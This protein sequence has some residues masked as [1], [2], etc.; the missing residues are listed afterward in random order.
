[1][2][3]DSIEVLNTGNATVTPSIVTDLNEDT[4]SQWITIENVDFGDLS[5]VRSD[6]AGNSNGH[7][8]LG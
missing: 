8:G 7:G 2:I 3:P 5:E 4:E 6:S 1:M